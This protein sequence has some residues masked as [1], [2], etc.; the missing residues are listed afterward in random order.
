[1]TQ[2]IT[3]AARSA[4]ADDLPLLAALDA[5]AAAG[6]VGVRGGHLEG[7]LHGRRG[8]VAAGFAE[9]MDAADGIVLVGTIDDVVVGLL[10][11][12]RSALPDGSTISTVT[13]LFVQEPA[14]GV[15]VGEKLLAAAVD[16]ARTHGCAGIDAR[17]LPGDRAT[18]N[19]FESFG[20]VARAI[21]VHRSLVDDAGD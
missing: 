12:T 2:P 4:T 11:A 13:D 6:I 21:S 8:D 15:G 16:D 10:A 7:Q 18:K 3:V 9:A 19:F 14:R 1:M 17:A 5:E 20:L